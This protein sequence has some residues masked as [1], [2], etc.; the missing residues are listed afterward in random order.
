MPCCRR[1]E[2]VLEAA[3]Q[4]HGWLLSQNGVLRTEEILL[5][6]L[7]WFQM[8][9][10]WQ[11]HE[12][13][14]NPTTNLASQ[15]R[16]ERQALFTPAVSRTCTP[17]TFGTCLTPCQTGLEIQNPTL[18]RFGT[19]SRKREGRD[20]WVITRATGKSS[21]CPELWAKS[22]FHLKDMLGDCCQMAL[23]VKPLT[24][25]TSAHVKIGKLKPLT[26]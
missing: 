25:Q 4:I 6:L 19:K 21:V 23:T 1:P 24:H 7:N 16:G 26:W 2:Q 9:S 20:S 10:F 17:A 18:Q 5:K 15:M 14:L 11:T 3:F 13:L 22:F 8:R 12:K